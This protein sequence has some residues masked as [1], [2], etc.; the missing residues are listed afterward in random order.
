MLSLLPTLIAKSA[1]N[2]L[3]KSQTPLFST[4]FFALT[5][6]FTTQRAFLNSTDGQSETVV[7]KN[8]TSATEQPAKTDGGRRVPSFAEAVNANKEGRQ[9]SFLNLN[10]SK[11]SQEER[12]PSRPVTPSKFL[13]YISS[14]RTLTH[15]DIVRFFKKADLEVV[16]AQ[17]AYVKGDYLPTGK[18]F[19]ELAQEITDPSNAKLKQLSIGTSRGKVILATESKFADLI[20]YKTFLQHPGKTVA[21]QGCNPNL[22]LSLVGKLLDGFKV[23]PGSSVPIPSLNRTLI[24]FETEEEAHRAVRE[25]HCNLV[26]Y[27]PVYLSVLN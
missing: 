2:A 18:W 5:R 3:P 1:L 27:R 6:T 20:K 25:L 7:E 8:D 22:L 10:K 17:H 23:I 16:K 12:R 26:I 24:S 19:V 11:I 4:R 21:F 14:S 15:G 13:I 9:R